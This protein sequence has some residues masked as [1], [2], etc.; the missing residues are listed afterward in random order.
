[1]SGYPKLYIILKK[2][3]LIGVIIKNPRR[4]MTNICGF[5][6]IIYGMQQE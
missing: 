1:M 6:Y 2:V 3:I 5:F 4:Q